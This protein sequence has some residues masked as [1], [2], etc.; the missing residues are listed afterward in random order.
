M[1]G[2]NGNELLIHE[3]FDYGNM[4]TLMAY[5]RNT[6]LFNET[7]YTPLLLF[8]FLAQLHSWHALGFTLG[9]GRRNHL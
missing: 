3:W 5:L 2:K 6:K 4:N 8:L 7:N 1:H 9:K